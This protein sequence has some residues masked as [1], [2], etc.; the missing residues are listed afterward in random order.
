MQQRDY[1]TVEKQNFFVGKSCDAIKKTPSK[2]NNAEQS[3]FAAER[4]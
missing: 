2:L 3:L 4:K 1:L